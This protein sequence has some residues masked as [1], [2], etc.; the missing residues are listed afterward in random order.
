MQDIIKKWGKHILAVLILLGLTVIYFSPAVFEGKVISQLDMQKVV[1]MGGSQMEQY[2]KTAQP[3]E[4]SVWSDAMFGGMPYITGYGDPAPNLPKYSDI[5]RPSKGLGYMDAGMIFTALVCFYLLM[6]IL[7]V[8]WWLAIAGAIAFAFETYNIILVEVGHITKMYVIAYMPV[9]LAG[10][11]LL[12]KRKY[13]WGTVLFLFGVALSIGNGHIQI[14]YYL[15]LLCIFIYLGY[16]VWSLK[17]KA[18]KELGI[19]TA[20]MVV[21][22]ILAVLPNAKN[23]YSHWDLGEH[24]TRGGSELTTTATEEK[25][26]SSGLDKDYAFAWSYGVKEL[27]TLLIP[28]VYGGPSVGTLGPDSH[29]YKEMRSKGA[30]V[31]KEIETYTYWGDKTTSGPVYFGALICFLFVFGM[32]V[33]KNPMK[34]WLFAGAVFLTFLALGRNFD[35]F[36]TFIFNYLPL[37]NKFRTVEMALIIPG[38]VFPIIAIW[39]LKDFFSKNIDDQ[40]FKRGM[41]TS[42]AITG[43]LCLIVWLVPSFLLDFQSPN[44]AHYQLPDWY[45]NAL[46]LDRK[47]I[48]TSD[49]FRSLMFILAGAVLLFWYFKSKNKAKTATIVSACIAVLVLTDLWT[50]DKRY[51][52]DSNFSRQKLHESYKPSVA[53]NMILEDKDHPNFR[54]LNFNSTF[55]ETSTSYFH[56]SVGG[57]HAAKLQRYQDLIDH[58]LIVEMNS[59]VQTAQTSQSV[60]GIMGA[61][62]NTPTLNMLNTRYVI[63][64]PGQPPIMNPYAYGNAWFVQGIMIVDNAD[65]EI[66][67]LDTI[68]PLKT[69]VIDRRFETD[70]KEFIPVVDSTATIQL[71]SYRPNKL[72]YSSRTSSD[73]LAVFSEIYYQ[74]G[75]KAY[76]D[77]KPAPHFRADWTLRAMIVPAGEHEIMF[78]FYPDAYV[79]AAYVESYSSFFILLLLIAAIGYS[80]WEGWKKKK[81]ED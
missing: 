26:V 47:S 61:F 60:Q 62:A 5:E 17:Q 64:D 78:E 27:L 72:I 67:A 21:C 6:C 49:A 13:I 36:N 77:G 55:Q 30:Q 66:K 70:V 29:L 73:Q 51:L 50:V 15:V 75:W 42:L 7:G 39:G 1:G 34:W 41:I 65:A 33:I 18:F 16:V 74:P 46:L 32:F 35:S 81:I 22:V 24:S 14:T 8:N 45:Y 4:F 19:V 25:K 40:L 59:I 37:Y 57:Y 53:D 10:M 58:R 43:G 52:N 23:L 11:A 56:H 9:L 54:V 12:F 31:G 38:L 3:G 79:K 63:V 80:L 48:A 20:I 2:E 28:D 69:A 68:N 44:D 71:D 76:I